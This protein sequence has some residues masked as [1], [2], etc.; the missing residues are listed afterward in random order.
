[1]FNTSLELYKKIDIIGPRIGLE[2]S[3]STRY[4][5]YTGATTSLIIYIIVVASAIKIASDAWKRQKPNVTSQN[6]SLPYTEIK[7]SDLSLSFNIFD[8]DGAPIK[9][10]S[11]YIYLKTEEA[12]NGNT[13]SI[14]II[15]KYNITQ[16]KDDIDYS[17]CLNAGDGKIRN[18]IYS[19]N[20][21]ALRIKMYKCN[22]KTISNIDINSEDKCAD[23]LEEAFN[24]LYL[25]INYSSSYYDIQSYNN[26]IYNVSSIKF[27]P[28]S[29]ILYKNIKMS[30][31]IGIL[32]T[33]KGW[34]FEEYQEENFIQ[35]NEFDTN[36][37]TVSTNI[38]NPELQMFQFSCSKIVP[39]VIRSYTKLTDMFSKVGGMATAL[40]VIIE[41]VFYHFLRFNYLKEIHKFS[42]KINNESVYLPSLPSLDNFNNNCKISRISK[43]SIN[44]DN[45]DIDNIKN[46]ASVLNSNRNNLNA[47][48]ANNEDSLKLNSNISKLISN[49][50]TINN[51]NNNNNDNSAF[52]IIKISKFDAA[53]NSSNNR[54]IC[55]RL[56]Q[57]NIIENPT[58]FQLRYNLND[59]NNI[60]KDNKKNYCNS[61]PHSKISEINS[62]SA[63]KICSNEVIIL[64]NNFNTNNM[65][66]NLKKN[67]TDEI[68]HVIGFQIK[69]KNNSS[70]SKNLNNHNQENDINYNIEVRRNKAHGLQRVFSNNINN[71]DNKND[72]I[73]NKD[74]NA[75]NDLP[76]PLKKIQSSNKNI[77][78]TGMN[79]NLSS[80]NNAAISKKER[81]NSIY[82]N[83]IFNIR[84]HNEEFY[85]YT[86]LDYLSSLL[87]LRKE[88]IKLYFD[89]IN[90]I[91]NSLD[92]ENYCRVLSTM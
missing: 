50:N 10:P 18:E 79:L 13:D 37:G 1:M 38:E 2:S 14:Q 15:E 81:T 8:A 34:L 39:K 35:L 12:N 49:T 36:Y 60:I 92:I 55:E 72:F 32:S 22:K 65:K 88:K 84:T 46:E 11:S 40:T 77:K 63:N 57:K 71:K 54:K 29:E 23:D 6:I 78:N 24:S 43:M 33:D 76:I 87:C 86:Y 85:N 16:C 59:D 9:Y 21:T 7:L 91:E 47:N 5:S 26:P 68:K 28:L 20:S 45:R 51:I 75:G 61:S 74:S 73:I 58:S 80:N 42:L 90:K 48:Y 25:I 70:I 66:D 41:L 67:K 44:N 3:N 30:F 53:L 27:I 89:F 4:K 83:N 64:K 56:S 31:Y 69:S 52:P 19:S 62:Y 17:L 82:L